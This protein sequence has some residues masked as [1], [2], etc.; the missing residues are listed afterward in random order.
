MRAVAIC[1]VVVLAWQSLAS[2]QVV[3]AGRVADENGVSLPGVKVEA[4]SGA[5]RIVAITDSA[6]AF[7]LEAP[8]PGEYEIRVGRSSID[9]PLRA[10]VTLGPDNPMIRG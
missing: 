4:V 10:V 1:G 3:V 2:A 5:T 9:L 8:S 6:G 7:N